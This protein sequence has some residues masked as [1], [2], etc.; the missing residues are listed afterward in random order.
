MS[1]RVMKYPY[2][3]GAQFRHFPFRMY[4]E[5]DWVYRSVWILELFSIVMFYSV[6]RAL[7]YLQ[8]L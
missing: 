6:F 2:T 3:V 5:K 4:F 8:F 7:L 1:G